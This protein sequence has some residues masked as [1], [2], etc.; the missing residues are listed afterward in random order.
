MTLPPLW[1]TR[2]TAAIA[3]ILAVWLGA[4]LAQGEY[5]W[6]TVV[7]GCLLLLSARRLFRMPIDALLLGC[8][9]FGY[10]AGNRGFAQISLTSGFPLLPAEFVLL[11]AGLLLVVQG[12]LYRVPIVRRELLNFTIFVWIVIGA[13]RLLFDIRSFGF[14]AIRDFAM[15]YYAS[16][17][18][19]A[20]HIATTARHRHWLQ[21]ALIAGTLGMAVGYP[22]VQAFPDFFFGTLTLRGNPLIYYKADLVGTMLSA[23]AVL[24]YVRYHLRFPIVGTAVTLILLGIALTTNN[25]ASLVGLATVTGLLLL[26]RQWKFAATQAVAGFV[27]VIAILFFAHLTNTSWKQTP[28]HGV[29]ERVVSIADPFGMR[30]YSGE[31][32]YF[33]GDNNRFRAVWWEAVFLETIDGNPWTGLGFGYDLARQF[34]REYYPEQ[35]EEFD[36]RSPHNIVL[37]VFARMGLLGLIP[38]VIVGTLIAW[39]IFQSARRDNPS[40]GMW[41]VAWAILISA[42]FGVVLEGPMGAVIFWVTLGIANARNDE[43]DAESA[44]FEAESLPNASPSV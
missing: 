38:F 3:A 22:L 1:H 6:P 33:K 29:Y 11:I 39:R 15:V 17:F 7:T 4:G 37:T 16:F 19:I 28:L 44:S 12:A 21:A 32:T 2:I 30:T 14:L 34:V 26:G 23:G 31:N 10:L 24:I 40:L 36:T 25:R 13:I 42:C 20:Q 27:A 35:G 41:C 8:I 5:F 18:F 9:V 43:D